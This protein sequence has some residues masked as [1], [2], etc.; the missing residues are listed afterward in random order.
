MELEELLAEADALMEAVEPI[1]VPATLGKKTVGVR[2]LPMSGADWRG[3]VLQHPPR[4]DVPQDL[5][6][7]YNVDDVVSAYP[8]VALI[9]DDRVDD[10]V[11]VT[12]DGE[13]KSLW[14]ETWA[15]ITATGRK[16]VATEMW[17]AHELTP[18]QLVLD[19]G[20]D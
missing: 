19:A 9:I 15:K 12:E 17:A 3:L 5:R 1:T 18:E 14:P 2:F 16:D 4:P 6:L 7:G 10:M 11:R 13:R 20:K 8:A